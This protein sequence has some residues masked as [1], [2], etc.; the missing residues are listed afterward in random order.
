MIRKFYKLFF[1]LGVIL[2]SFSVSG[3]KPKY[4]GFVAGEYVSTEVKRHVLKG[5][6]DWAFSE[7]K[8]NLNNIDRK[9]YSEAS[10]VNV[11]CDA[12]KSGDDRYFSF[13]LYVYVDELGEY[14]KIDL[15]DFHCQKGASQTYYCY[16]IDRKASYNISAVTFIY[17]KPYMI[18]IHQGSAYE[19]EKNYVESYYRISPKNNNEERKV[20]SRLF[21]LSC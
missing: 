20:R 10:G 5:P 16:P 2:F 8:L 11:I 13:E 14:C 17:D 7:I 18:L 21:S 6:E 3:C 4:D 1:V 15:A 12:T 9:T 19:S